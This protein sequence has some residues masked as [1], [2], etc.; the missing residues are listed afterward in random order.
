[1]IV[2]M[3]AVMGLMAVATPVLV[4]TDVSAANAVEELKKG[5]NAAGGSTDGNKKSFGAIMKTV[6]NVILYVLGA[7]SVIMIVFG[8]FRYTVS[9]GDASKVKAAKDTILYAVV[10][11]VVALLAFA[12]VNF[13]L[14]SLT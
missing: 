11:L 7:V 8:G 3:M 10:G 13:V 4:A 9:A 6:V 14:T 5:M 1:M 12:V 2:S